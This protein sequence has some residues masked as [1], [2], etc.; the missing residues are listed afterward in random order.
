M[1]KDV[2]EMAKTYQL[3]EIF[4]FLSRMDEYMYHSNNSDIQEFKIIGSYDRGY[5]LYVTNHNEENWVRV[6][7]DRL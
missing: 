1:W 2:K 7:V 4:E 3:S 5:R 6:D